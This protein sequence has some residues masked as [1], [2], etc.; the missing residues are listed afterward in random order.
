MFLRTEELK[1][2][3]PELICMSLAHCCLQQ[4]CWAFNKSLVAP[5]NLLPDPP[6]SSVSKELFPSYLFNV[7]ALRPIW[8]Y[9]SCLSPPTCGTSHS[10]RFP[11]HSWKRDSSCFSQLPWVVKEPTRSYFVR[12]INH[13]HSFETCVISFLIRLFSKVEK[14]LFILRKKKQN[15]CKIKNNNP[16]PN[17]SSP[18]KRRNNSLLLL[19]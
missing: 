16:K 9:L 7:C 3:P 15:P 19:F 5:C 2:S 8:M 13:L 14:S 18:K 12:L 10:R 1:K 11:A 6:S 4:R 17:P